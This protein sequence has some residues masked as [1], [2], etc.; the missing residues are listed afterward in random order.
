MPDRDPTNSTDENWLARPD[1]VYSLLLLAVAIVAVGI[2]APDGGLLAADPGL[3][4]VAFFLVF[5]L[6][7]I[8]AGF[9]HP[10]LGHVSFDRVA[11]VMSILVLG[12]ID[13]AWINGL[14]SFIYPWKRLREGVPASLVIIAA[15]HNA[16]L[17]MLV[18]LVSGTLFESLSGPVPLTTLDLKTGTLLVL[19]IV[20]MQV[21][22]DLGMMVILKL[23]DLNP[24]QVFNRFAAMVENVAAA[25]GIVLAIAWNAMPLAY[26]VLLLLVFASGMLVIMQY[27]LMRY[28]LEKIVEDRTEE[29]RV[30]AEEFERQ[31]THDKL[32]GLPNRR[33]ADDYLQRQ[34]DLAKRN[35]STGALA[36]ADVDHFKR[37]NDTH[38]HAVGDKVLERVAD[39]LSDGC[40]KT[41]FVARYGG[42]EFL[43]YFPDTDGERAGQVCE[44][45]RED[46][47]NADW[48]DIVPGIRVTLSFGLAE[49][50]DTD[51]SATVINQAD[52][53]L[54]RAKND[55]RNRV[56]AS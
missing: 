28:R 49:I 45:L 44:E 56:V 15:V 53:R 9:P 31:A 32:T 18:I 8:T 24:W 40:R 30:Q 11:H 35:D 20:S 37:I 27:A 46:M 4:L 25:T 19:L 55:G 39:L 6:F 14:A 43:L 22:N 33:H 48:S 54:Y 5:G 21:L 36:L 17:M 10:V 42:E 7:A 29:L 3:P 13:A 23:R 50:R 47:Q 41:D 51:R 38:S 2:A 16:G 26:F 34:I 52:M 1:F 12:P